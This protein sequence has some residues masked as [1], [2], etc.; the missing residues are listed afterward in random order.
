[1]FR[2]R[3]HIF[4]APPDDGG[5]GG[6]AQG[7]TGGDTGTG[8]GSPS[9]S[10]DSGGQGQKTPSPEGQQQHGDSG[11]SLGGDFLNRVPE[12][13]RSILEPYVKQWDA[14]VTRR[15]Q[16]LHSQ[17]QPYEALGLQ[18][19]DLQ[20]AA[21]A[22][23][24]M[25]ENPQV[26]IN[27]LQTQLQQGQG[28]EQGRQGQGQGLPTPEAVK[29]LPPEFQAAWQQQQQILAQQQQ[30]LEALSQ[31]VL[32][33]QQS[34]Q[35][36]QEDK[37]L[38]DYLGLLKQEYGEFDEDYVMA[39]MLRGMDGEAAVKSFIELMDNVPGNGGGRPPVPVLSGGG[40][41]P[42]DSFDPTKASRKETK[43]LVANLLR[44]AAEQGS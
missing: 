8:T 39:K 20:L 5:S 10:G 4:Y 25:N 44:T 3:V 14:G 28:G 32:G 13:H 40:I 7:P 33:Q 15:F 27:I 41:M 29:A 9:P 18:Q 37:A 6:G 2:R 1:M 16:E 36:Q 24:L 22:W 38:S 43:D 21:D 11:S 42:Q 23:K 19:E 26:L 17:L 35:Q 31:Q 12:H 30:A 34:T